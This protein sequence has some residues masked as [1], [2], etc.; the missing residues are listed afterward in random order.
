MGGAKTPTTKNRAGQP[1]WPHYRSETVQHAGQAIS[2]H[3]QTPQE[4]SH[5]PFKNPDRDP[6]KFDDKAV[7]VEPTN[8]L[9]EKVRRPVRRYPFAAQIQTDLQFALRSPRE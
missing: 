3:F 7:A 8:D 1:S 9:R 4:G 2:E 5:E 6:K